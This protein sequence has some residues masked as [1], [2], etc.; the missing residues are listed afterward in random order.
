[1]PLR[2]SGTAEFDTGDELL[3]VPALDLREERV[4][5]AREPVRVDHDLVADR[6]PE[7]GGLGRYLIVLF[8]ASTPPFSR[9][10]SVIIRTSLSA[11]PSLPSFL[12]TR[13]TNARSSATTSST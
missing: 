12:R 9:M 10:E 7:H 1:M 5:Q 6:E 3:R 13:C 2:R 11:F 8:A 4:E